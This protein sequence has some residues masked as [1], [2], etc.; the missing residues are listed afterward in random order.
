MLRAWTEDRSERGRMLRIRRVAAQEVVFVLSGWIEEKDVRE[1]QRLFSLESA[2]R[3]IV[4][5]L[6]DVTLVD[7]EAVSFLGQC[8][9]DGIKLENCP[10]YIRRGL[11]MKRAGC[12]E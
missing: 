1:L 4:I 8:E 11:K 10:A 3:D 5:N 7:R 6:S 9:L 12:R 2:G